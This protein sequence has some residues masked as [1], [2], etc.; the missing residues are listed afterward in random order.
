MNSTSPPAGKYLPTL[1]GWRA[2]AILGVMVCH[3][4]DALFH[5]G[6]SHPHAGWHALTRHGALGVDIFFGI[7]GFL[8]CSRLLDEQRTSGHISLARFYARRIFRILP[9]YMA[10]LAVLAVLAAAGLVAVGSRTWFSCLLFYRNYLPGSQGGGDYTGH[11]WSLSVEEHFYLLWPGLLLLCGVRRARR[12]V[13]G[14]AVGIAIW[15]VVEFRHAWLARWL[16]G[17]GFFP[18]TDIRLDGLLWGC[19]AAL[20]LQAPGWRARLERWL[21]PWT[22]LALLAAFVACVHYQ[23]PLAMMW[24]ALLIPLLLLGTV[25]HPG[26]AAGR[27]LETGAMRWVGRLSYSLYLWNS[28]FFAGMDKARPLRLG[29]LQELPWSI[30]PVFAC[31]A[32]SY[33]LVER[34]MIRLG[35]SLTARRGRPVE[36]AP[37][38]LAA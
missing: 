16:P 28:L 3:A 9:P 15:R 35:H 29:A 13:V 11:F 19:W 34:P 25:L 31:A 8:I 5:S 1:D 32:L 24:Q 12:V 22:W 4:G 20:L 36:H 33:Y 26:A 23:P 18:R 17:V 21:S 2:I 38:A 37:R 7:S 27:I 30:L 14:L 6:G 10:Y